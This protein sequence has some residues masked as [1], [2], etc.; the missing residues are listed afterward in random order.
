MK[1][2]SQFILIDT[3]T[4]PYKA[5]I[6]PDVFILEEFAKQFKKEN[7]VELTVGELTEMWKYSKHEAQ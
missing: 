7:D 5:W 3:R 2:K 4:D 6:F 1:G